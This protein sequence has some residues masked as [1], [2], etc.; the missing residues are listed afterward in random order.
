MVQYKDY[1]SRKELFYLGIDSEKEIEGLSNDYC[2]ETRI[3]E[4]DLSM[5]NIYSFIKASQEKLS[6]NENAKKVSNEILVNN[7]SK[8]IVAAFYDLG[9]LGD[10]DLERFPLNYKLDEPTKTQISVME[11]AEDEVINVEEV[12]SSTPSKERKLW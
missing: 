6:L 2:G 8:R 11:V 5:K 7:V 9:I 1:F 3:D 10:L 12:T 4:I